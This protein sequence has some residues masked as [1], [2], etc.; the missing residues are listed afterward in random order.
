MRV[1]AGVPLVLAGVLGLAVLTGCA[2]NQPGDTN[3]GPGY[4]DNVSDLLVKVPALAADPCRSAQANTLYPNCGRYVAQV[5]NTISAIRDNLPNQGTAT[6]TLQ[7]AVNRFQQMGCDTITGQPSSSQ[8][9]ECPAALRT[10]GTE[11]D[12]LSKALTSIPTSQ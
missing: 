2:D 5:A 10:I 9:Q 1:T 12:T 8:A 3:N 11:L 4:T 6:G 7:Q